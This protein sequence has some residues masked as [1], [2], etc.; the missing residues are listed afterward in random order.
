MGNSEL[1]EPLHLE[2]IVSL[3]AEK[4]SISLL[5]WLNECER[6][7]SDAAPEEVSNHQQT[8]QRDLLNILSLPSPAPGHVLRDSLGRC[9]VLIFERG[10][11]KVLFDTVTVF[12]AKINQIKSDRE[13]KQKQYNTRIRSP[14]ANCCSAWIYCLGEILAAAGDSVVHLLSDIINALIKLSRSSHLDAGVRAIALGTIKKALLKQDAVK[15]EGVYRDAWKSIKGGLSDKSWIVQLR[16]AEVLFLLR[17]TL[18]QAPRRSMQSFT[19][20]I[21][22]RV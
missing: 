15:D 4:Q 7:L 12:S 14:F 18:T 9:F 5:N 17:G 3:P 2:N 16:A 19:H 20:N 21:A 13:T 6:F 10:D 22:R 11:R 1:P 8:F